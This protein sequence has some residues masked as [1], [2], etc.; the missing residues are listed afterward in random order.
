MG[1]RMGSGGGGSRGWTRELVDSLQ[2]GVDLPR[3]GRAHKYCA[4][5][6]LWDAAL[7]CRFR[8]R[9]RFSSGQLT[10]SNC[11]SRLIGFD[12]RTT[13]LDGTVAHDD[14]VSACA[15]CVKNASTI[16]TR[17]DQ[18]LKKEMEWLC[19]YL[20]K[21]FSKPQSPPADEETNAP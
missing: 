15:V 16:I 21:P 17:P 8:R 12:K 20:H 5:R 10:S 11:E 18:K 1:G 4:R 14:L 3:K 7:I 6:A 13:T 9:R 19:Q 2:G